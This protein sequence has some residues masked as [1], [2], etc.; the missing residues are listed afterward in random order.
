[1]GDT[2]KVDVNRRE[3]VRV[4]MDVK[5]L[6]KLASGSTEICTIEN[7]TKT[8]VYFTTYREYRRGE[9]VMILFPYDPTQPVAQESFRHGEVV[10][11]EEREGSMKKG[12]AVRMLNIFLKTTR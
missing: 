7:M 1:M 5:A 9:T 6:V 11:M 2:A 12:V 10:R 8:G 4:K 3:R